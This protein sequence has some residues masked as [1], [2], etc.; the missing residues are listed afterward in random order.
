MDKEAVGMEQRAV[1]T[2]EMMAAGARSLIDGQENRPG[3]SWADEALW[4]YEAMHALAQQPAAQAAPYAYDVT[5][6]DGESELVYAAYMERHGKDM[7]YVSRVPLYAALPAQAP[8]LAD[9]QFIATH[10][11]RLAALLGIK[12]WWD[13]ADRDARIKAALLSRAAPSGEPVAWVRFRSDGG[14]E[15]PI[16]DTDPRM[17]DV[18]RKSGAW[19]ALGV[20]TPQPSGGKHE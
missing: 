18:R 8:G 9:E 16:L 17:D 13:I 3:S 1:V 19:T 12:K 11:E 2:E 20:I 5:C 10:G 4:C 7:D 14:I 15:G 6:A